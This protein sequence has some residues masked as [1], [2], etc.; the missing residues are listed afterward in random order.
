MQL[1]IYLKRLKIII[2]NRWGLRYQTATIGSDVPYKVDLEV[3]TNSD[4]QTR[5]SD[6]SE[7]QITSTMLCAYKL[8]K[9]SCTV[10]WLSCNK[11]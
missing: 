7:T 5:I 4:C 10:S 8:G 6:A 2:L 1:Y 11:F 3:L 9:D